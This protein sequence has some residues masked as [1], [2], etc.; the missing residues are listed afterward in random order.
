MKSRSFKNWEEA[1]KSRA[2]W[3]SQ[4]NS[5]RNQKFQ[6]MRLKFSLKRGA[7]FQGI[8]SKT[9]LLLIHQNTLLCKCVTECEHIKCTFSQDH[10]KN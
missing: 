7:T 5:R 8:H 2:N 6:S 1:L 4:R 10:Y 9:I 3:N